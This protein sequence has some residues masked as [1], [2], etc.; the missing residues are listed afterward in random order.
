MLCADY[1]GRAFVEIALLYV[2]YFEDLPIDGRY[3][4]AY[5]NLRMFCCFTLY[6]YNSGGT[7]VRSSSN[8]YTNVEILEYTI[9]ASGYYTIKIQVADHIISSVDKYVQP[10]VVWIVD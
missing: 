9:P 4:T 7:I 6:L 10:Y 3:K 8:A 1:A 5:Y 2:L